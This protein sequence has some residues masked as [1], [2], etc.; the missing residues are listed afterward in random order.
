MAI[1]S[2]Q[3]IASYVE[4]MTAAITAAGWEKSDEELAEKLIAYP[5]D[6]IDVN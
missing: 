6:Q 3:F 4:K 1:S 5:D 2:G